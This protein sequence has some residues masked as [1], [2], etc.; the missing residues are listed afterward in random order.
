MR[1][2]FLPSATLAVAMM[3]CVPL[4]RA[5]LILAENLTTGVPTICAN[6][7]LS[8][9]PALCISLVG[10]GGFSG[11]TVTGFSAQSNSP[12]TSTDSH[13]FGSALEI[14][15]TGSTTASFTL[16]IGAQ[17]FTL[18]TIQSVF[19]SQVA[20][21]STT[22]TSS[23][24]LTSCVDPTNQGPPPT[25]TF[26]CGLGGTFV[27]NPLLPATGSSSEQNTTEMTI[28]ALST[29]FS[30]QQSF[31]IVVGPGSDIN[32]STSA[33]LEAVPEPASTL[34]LGSGLLGIAMLIRKRVAGRS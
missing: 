3:S 23:V 5:N 28:A 22:G 16:L 14:T 32:I 10:T 25:Q 20:I 18:P 31:Q 33:I 30:I 8:T 7:V 1:K 6:T 2:F 11:I 4:A 24:T 29:P 9:G 19:S 17:G 26:L 27:H 21:T 13:L 15:D 34:L 12:G